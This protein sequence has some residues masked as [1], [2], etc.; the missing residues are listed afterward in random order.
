MNVPNKIIGLVLIGIGLILA[1]MEYTVLTTISEIAAWLGNII[2]IS[3]NGTIGLTII[4][5][6]PAAGLV[7]GL[8]V[9]MLFVFYLA[10]DFMVE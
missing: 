2:G 8:L 1:Y 9:L 6:L 4:L 10:R 3:D 7:V 5:T